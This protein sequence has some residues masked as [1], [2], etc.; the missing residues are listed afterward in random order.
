MS[1]GLGTW[2]GS[3]SK[4]PPLVLCFINLFVKTDFGSQ[5]FFCCLLEPSSILRGRLRCILQVRIVLEHPYLKE[6]NPVPNYERLM[7]AYSHYE[8]SNVPVQY[9]YF[10]M[11][12]N[13]RTTSLIMSK[14]AFWLTWNICGVLIGLPISIKD[15]SSISCLVTRSTPKT[16]HSYMW[17]HF[18]QQ[19]TTW[20]DTMTI[21]SI[22]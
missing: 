5:H 16:F 22:S 1:C 6:P 7:R 17:Y 3:F 4:S 21:F 19:R 18:A 13:P 2:F 15:W 9:L 11:R 12:R 10:P 14:R 8:E 20:R